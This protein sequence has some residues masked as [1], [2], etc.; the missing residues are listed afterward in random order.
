M[1]SVSNLLA[2]FE[3]VIRLSVLAEREFVRTCTQLLWR[4]L[5]DL[6]G[7]LA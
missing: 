1:S 5:D 2:A 6:T 3:V 7:V 4:S